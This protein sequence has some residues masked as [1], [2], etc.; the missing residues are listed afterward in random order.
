MPICIYILCN[1]TY[2]VTFP[3]VAIGRCSRKYLLLKCGRKIRAEFLEMLEVAIF[4]QGFARVNGQFFETILQT[5]SEICISCRA[6][7]Y[8]LSNKQPV[9]SSHEVSADS[10]KIVYDEAN[11]IVNLH[12]FLQPL[13]YPSYTFSP[14]E[15]FVPHS[16][17]QNNLQNSSPL[18]TSETALIFSSILNHSQANQNN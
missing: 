11:F 9:G 16:P 15:S 6:I 7:Q 1:T 10:S 4:S 3:K 8:I 18:D 13:A 5:Y 17:R 14:S 2:F 12:S